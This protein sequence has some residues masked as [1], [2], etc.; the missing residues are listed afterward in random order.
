MGGV[1][2]VVTGVPLRSVCDGVELQPA[3]RPNWFRVAFAGAQ[4][5]FGKGTPSPCASGANPAVLPIPQAPP[6]P[7]KASQAQEKA[8]V[9]KRNL[10][11]L[12]IGACALF[13]LLPFT[14][15]VFPSIIVLPI[16][17]L[18]LPVGAGLFWGAFELYHVLGRIEQELYDI[19][20]PINFVTETT[21]S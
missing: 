18:L 8:L 2:R 10:V 3:A 1:T 15:F 17:L 21:I 11:F 9:F 13:S 7:N 12:A 19:R 5:T 14:L 16:L 20:Y 6:S 4:R